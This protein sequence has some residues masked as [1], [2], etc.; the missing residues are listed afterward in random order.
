[1]R[2]ACGCAEYCR[3]I[4]IGAYEGRYK[5]T[6]ADITLI[7]FTLCNGFRLLAYLPQ[8][9]KAATDPAGAQ[10]VSFTTW[11]LFLFANVSAVAY[12]LVNKAD[13]T[14]AAMF[15]GNAAGCAAI[16]AIGA[17]KRSQYR[18]ALDAA[19]CAQDALQ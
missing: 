10:A 13:W 5:M 9:A 7:A 2:V 17:W 12:A 11:G 8:I 4:T 19:Q 1:M 16:L 15:L 18:S 3:R 14:M 6:A